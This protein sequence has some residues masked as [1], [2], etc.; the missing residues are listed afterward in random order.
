[1]IFKIPANPSLSMTLQYYDPSLEN[2]QV[3]AHTWPSPPATTTSCPHQ[4]GLIPVGVIYST[5][6][7]TLMGITDFSLSPCRVLC[8]YPIR[9]SKCHGW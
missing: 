1:M 4:K 7:E 5:K 6:K 9:S 8:P 2:P 3:S